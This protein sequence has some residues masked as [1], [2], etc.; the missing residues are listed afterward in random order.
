MIYFFQTEDGSEVKIGFTGTH[1]DSRR[2]SLQ[3]Q[4]RVKLTCL[5]VMA[6]GLSKEEELHRKFAE[7]RTTGEWFK[8]APELMVFIAGNAGDLSDL[9]EDYKEAKAGFTIYPDDETLAQIDALAA[10][11]ERKRAP[12][13]LLL[14]KAGLTVI[15]KKPRP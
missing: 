14:I 12:M 3:S 1:P 5:G 15:A 13:A 4:Y 6:G 9:D 8:A 7:H 11:Q 10:T 2:S